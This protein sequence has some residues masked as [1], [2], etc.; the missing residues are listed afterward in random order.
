MTTR[1]RGGASLRVDIT[2]EGTL[3]AVRNVRIVLAL[4]TC[5]C[6]LVASLWIV[7]GVRTTASP[8]LVETLPLGTQD[9]VP[10]QR[11]SGTIADSP[12]GFVIDGQAAGEARVPV[13]APMPRRGRLVARIWAYSAPGVTVRADLLA[14]D[15]SVHPLGSVGRWV[16]HDVDITRVARGGPWALRVRVDNASE[17]PALFLDQLEIVDV[18]A[19]ALPSSSPAGVALWLALVAAA[20][21]ALAGRLA[22]HWPLPIGVAVLA[23][24]VWPDVRAMALDPLAP[25]LQPLWAAA[26]R[27][28]WLGL[29][30]GLLSGTFGGQS[31]L[32]VQLL[33]A[34]AGVAGAGLPAARAASL[35]VATG[36][37]GTGYALGY[38]VAGRVGAITTVTLLLL[39]DVFRAGALGTPSPALFL[40]GALLALGVHCCLARADAAA[41]GVCGALCGLAALADPLLLP[42]VV[43]VLA[44]V[45]AL[46]GVRGQR[47]RALGMGLLVL[48]IVLTPS[49]LSVAD[50]NDGQALADVRARATAARDAE[51]PRR[52]DTGSTGLI[53]YVIGDH[54]PSQA[55]GE[56]LLGADR[57]VGAMAAHPA[58]GLAAALGFALVMLGAIYTLTVRH[59]RLLVLLSAA[60]LCFAFWF[61]GRRIDPAAQAGALWWPALAAAAGALVYAIDAGYVRPRLQARRARAAAGEDVVVAAERRA[62]QPR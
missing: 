38:R 34:A 31:A 35:L 6:A 48:A 21:L 7:P 8:F 24:A 43:V 45:V 36:A 52:R 40:A 49:R 11:H 1:S 47:L 28:S 19:D 10:G 53:S 25:S 2:S 51:F 5:A 60:G 33:H 12:D 23:A 42:G 41:A 50:Q 59:L 57:A 16:A 61:A 32:S 13:R 29:H 3:C 27:A 62:L 14:A 20:L 46:R 26:G 37:L 18:P 44:V 22:R 4:A 17:T 55:V 39:S 9:P 30:D 15:H 58:T 54:S 56:A